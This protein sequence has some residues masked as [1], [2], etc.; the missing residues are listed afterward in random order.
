MNK[1]FLD[2]LAN[3]LLL[4]VA[5]FVLAFIQINPKVITKTEVPGEYRVL[6]SWPDESSDDVD[7]YILDPSQ[8]LVFFKDKDVGLFNL[9][10]D[11]QGNINDYIITPNGK[12]PY[13]KNQEI[14]TIR[15]AVEGEYIVNVHMFAKRD[16][17]T[18][19]VTVELERIHPKRI[20]TAQK[21]FLSDDNDEKTVFRFVVDS[22][23]SVS[24]T[25]YL[26]RKLANK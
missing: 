16:E 22:T 18:I 1:S 21:I 19:P 6:V 5:L 9:D 2:I 8:N 17:S 24:S 3:M 11:D 7:T 4:F 25:N 14:I 26:S 23:G 15:K 10:R 12:I 13:R 20:I